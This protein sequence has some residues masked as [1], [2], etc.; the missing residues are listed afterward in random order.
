MPCRQLLVKQNGVVSYVL[1]RERRHADAVKR[2][3]S[4]SIIRRRSPVSPHAL[5]GVRR[6]YVTKRSGFG[7]GKGVLLSRW[8]HVCKASFLVVCVCVRVCGGGP[9]KKMS[10]F[11]S[12]GLP[13]GVVCNHF[14]WDRLE[15]RCCAQ[16]GQRMP[17]S[18]T[19]HSYIPTFLGEE[20]N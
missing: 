1:A 4:R 15:G 3:H 9:I 13:L 2:S 7:L 11:C 12:R 6:I 8:H 5:L 16:S 20:C 18:I 19:I 14:E 10:G 17:G